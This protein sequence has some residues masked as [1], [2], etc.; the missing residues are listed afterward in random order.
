MQDLE[1]LR[2]IIK[3]LVERDLYYVEHDFIGFFWFIPE[4]IALKA[5]DKDFSYFPVLFECLEKDLPREVL[6]VF[7]L[8]GTFKV[9]TLLRLARECRKMFKGILYWRTKEERFKYIKGGE[10][11]W[12]F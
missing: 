12:D 7:W 5:L 10:Q 3:L 4:E 9:A 8:A 1:L 11:R 6:Y 2:R